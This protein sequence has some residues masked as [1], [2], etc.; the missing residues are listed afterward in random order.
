MKIGNPNNNSF[1]LNCPPEFDLDVAIQKADEVYVITAFA[2]QTGWKLIKDA[3]KTTSAHVE[4]LAGLDFCRTEPGVLKQ[5]VSPS[6]SH[7]RPHLYT[8][9][10]TFHPKVIIV[11]SKAKKYNF[12]IVGSGNMSQGGYI[13]NVECNVYIDNKEQVSNLTSWYKDLVAEGACRLNEEMIEAYLPKYESAK[14]NITNINKDEITALEDINDKVKKQA[15]MREWHQAVKDAKE[16]FASGKLDSGWY[17]THKQAVKDIKSHLN[18]PSFKF[19]KENW[20]DF[21]RIESLGNLNNIPKNRVYD[22]EKAKLVKG[23]KQLINETKDVS[24]RIDFLVENKNKTGIS[25]IGVN[26]VSKIL[27]ASKP[28]YW[29][30]HNDPIFDALKHYGYKESRGGTRGTKYAAY[31]KLMREFCKA[32]GAKDMLA[33]DCFFYDVNNKLKNNSL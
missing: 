29:P 9:K 22:E 7:V 8:K 24:E 12:A 21:Y 16:F 13:K 27:T 17:K 26:T 2:H 14:R 6:Y 4:L 5:W 23:F 20:D 18:Y 25:G 31:A 11:R 10:I 19:S 32:T 15:E 28:K 30:T 1:I 33:I 3:I